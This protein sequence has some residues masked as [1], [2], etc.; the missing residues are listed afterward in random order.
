[1]KVILG[2]MLVKL[3]L[4][5]IFVEIPQEDN[6]RTLLFLCKDF[7]DKLLLKDITRGKSIALCF[8]V[9]RLLVPRCLA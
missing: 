4:I 5:D 7:F 1:M 3:I 8:E 9:V 2:E 6:L